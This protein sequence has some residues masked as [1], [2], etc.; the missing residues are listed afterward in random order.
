MERRC[1]GKFI[2]IYRKYTDTTSSRIIE[3]LRS[4]CIANGD[5]AI[6]YFYVDGSDHQ[7]LSIDT[8]YSSFVY[9]LALQSHGVPYALDIYLRHR[10]PDDVTSKTELR[11]LYLELVEG[12]CKIYVVID[13]L[14][15]CQEFIELDDMVQVLTDL[16]DRKMM[17]TNILA[18]SRQL[19]Q[20]RR[21]FQELGAL[22]VSMEDD[23]AHVDMETALHSQLSCSAPFRRWPQTLR[24]N[25]EST[26]LTK[27]GGS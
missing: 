22:Q 13:A 25:V 7:P 4:E 11:R 6:L 23:A 20:L 8:F 15:E 27:A 12:F 24:N 10:R 17:Q 26:L 1:F 14:D 18:S 21:S 5:N 16:L 2:L 9:Q 19:E 3:D